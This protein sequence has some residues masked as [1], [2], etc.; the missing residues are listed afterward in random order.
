MTVVAKCHRTG[1]DVPRPNSIPAEN[2][3]DQIIQLT[4]VA[5]GLDLRLYSERD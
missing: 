3:W 5:F 2:C 4:P 1:L